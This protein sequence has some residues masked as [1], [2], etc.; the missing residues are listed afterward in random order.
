MNAFYIAR[1][2]TSPFNRTIINMSMKKRKLSITKVL[3]L[4]IISYA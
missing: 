2:S 1:V 3:I 4:N